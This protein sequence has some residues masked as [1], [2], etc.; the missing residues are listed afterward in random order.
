MS[1]NN[2][3]ALD[4]FNALVLEFSKDKD[5]ISFVNKTEQRI[6]TTQDH[7]GVYMSFLTPYVKDNLS[8]KVISDALKLAG[9]NIKGVNSALMVLKGGA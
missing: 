7:Y 6:K 2:T 8:L 3:V 1:N 4:K 5:I 9:A